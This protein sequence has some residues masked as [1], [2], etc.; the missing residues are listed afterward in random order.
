LQV[1]QPEDG[2][3][4]SGL[5]IPPERRKELIRMSG[6]GEESEDEMTES[7]SEKPQKKDAKKH[8]VTIKEPE[9]KASQEVGQIINLVG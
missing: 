8:S 1:S 3:P 6:G 7:I 4:G 9:K 5:K 2:I